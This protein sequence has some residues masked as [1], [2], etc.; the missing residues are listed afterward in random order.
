VTN[1]NLN[2][3]NAPGTVGTSVL[4]ILPPG[5]TLLITGYGQQ[6]TGYFWVP[7]Q[8]VSNGMTGWVA[9]QYLDPGVQPAALAEEAAPATSTPSPEVTNPRYDDPVLRWLPEIGAASAASGLSPAQLAGLI[10]FMSGGDPA[11]ISENG[12][13]GLLQ[14]KPEEFAA[15]SVPEVAWHDPATNVNLGAVILAGLTAET[16]TFE[17]ALW[18]YFGDGCDA[19]GRCTADYVSAVM[20]AVADYDVL[21][22]DPAANGLSLLPA[23]WQAPEIVPYLADVPLRFEPVPPTEEA[24]PPATEPPAD[25]AIP[26]ELP[27]EEPTT[28]PDSSPEP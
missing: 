26:T 7:V 15:Y 8:R 21:I 14:V 17:A 28:P 25:T 13:R 11:V 10:S 4:A 27:T 24:P 20:S 22:A 3:R 23:D 16:G 9:D 2:L 18:A 1:T 6:A 19:N 12:A 5:T